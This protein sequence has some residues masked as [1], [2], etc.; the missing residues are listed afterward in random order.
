MK[1]SITFL[2]DFFQGITSELSC[3]LIVP[4]A[5]EIPEEGFTVFLNKEILSLVA[6]IYITSISKTSEFTTTAEGTP[7]YSGMPSA[8]RDF[9]QM[10][11]ND[12]M[13]FSFDIQLYQSIVTNEVIIPQSGN[14]KFDI[15]IK[16]SLA[17]V[18]TTTIN[19]TVTHAA[20]AT[21]STTTTNTLTHF[22]TNPDF[23]AEVE[24]APPKSRSAFNHK[25]F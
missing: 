9:R 12:L 19:S 18:I 15:N 21:T 7:N 10:K 1:R 2:S 23:T 24:G 3:C 16:K 17:A 5:N 22:T 6:S 11:A 20:F 8:T 13:V 25:G 4:R 14:S